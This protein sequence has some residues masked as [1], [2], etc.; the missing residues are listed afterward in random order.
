MSLEGKGPNQLKINKC[1]HDQLE[2][3]KKKP[4]SKQTKA[5]KQTSKQEQA[6]KQT[7]TQGD[8]NK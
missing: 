4:T 7:N 3:L 8:E 2:R 5:D 6:S 1:V